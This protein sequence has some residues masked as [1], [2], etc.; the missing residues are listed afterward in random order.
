MTSFDIFQ[1]TIESNLT[2]S[3]M[4]VYSNSWLTLV[5]NFH[6][7]Q[8]ININVIF[9]LHFPLRT[10]WRPSASANARRKGHYRETSK[11][12]GLK[13]MGIELNGIDLIISDIHLMVR[14]LF[15]LLYQLT[16][17]TWTKWQ[18]GVK[19]HRAVWMFE[20]V[21]F[22]WNIDQFL[23]VL[24]VSHGQVHWVYWFAGKLYRKTCYFAKK[25][26]SFGFSHIIHQCLD[27]V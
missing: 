12:A 18:S 7:F 27:S 24:F 21:G 10:L 6:H 5:M 1:I 14:L 20:H 2:R 8:T 26:K 23:W 9:F 3:P 22:D 25:G 11:S 13:K 17:S 15:E 4:D 19:L 16:I